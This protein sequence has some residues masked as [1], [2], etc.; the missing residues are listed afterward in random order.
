MAK[1]SVILKQNTLEAPLITALL[2]ALVLLVALS[3]GLGSVS[4]RGAGLWRAL[5]DAGSLERIILLDI[6]LPRTLLAPLIG[7]AFGMSGAALQG[8]LRNPL[9]EP[10]VLG[11]PQMAALGAAGAVF[12][13]GVPTTSLMLAVVA[14]SF[15]LGSVGLV[16]VVAGRQ[17]STSTLLIAGLAIASLASAMLSFVLALSDNPFALAEVVFWLI[18]SLEDRSWHHVM[19][20]APPIL[21]GL[22]LL[23]PTRRALSALVLGEETATS[24]G[25]HLPG[26]RWTIAFGVALAIGG[27]VAVA[28]AI[29]FVGLLA[30]HLVRAKVSHDPGRVLLPSALAGAVL[31]LAADCLARL[32]PSPTEIKVGMVTALVGVPVFLV[33]LMRN[34]ARFEEGL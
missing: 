8:F 25:F 14:I 15:A 12:L 24:L 21:L 18:G 7:A 20:A 1:N 16:A 26:I 19:I 29:G 28:G 5:F 10:S 2:V 30:P 13:G 27:A 32:I 34:R 23:L 31:V 9:A 4:L 11:A 33:I 6:R 17:A 3:L 22:S